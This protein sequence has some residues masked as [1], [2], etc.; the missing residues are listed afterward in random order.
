MNTRR[1]LAGFSLVELMVVVAVLAVVMALGIPSFAEWIANS[2]IRTAASSIL[3]GLQL[4]R[5]E[6]IRTNARVQFQLTGL[7]GGWQIAREAVDGT[8]QPQRCIFAG[9]ASV[10]SHPAPPSNA[11]LVVS[12]FSDTA[13]NTATVANLFIF[14]PNGWQGCTDIQPQQFFALGLDTTAI[15]EGNRN[16]RIAVLRGGGV[17]LCDPHASDT[18]A[19]LN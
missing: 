19:C 13:A 9:G 15:S 7:T 6:A 10:Q 8:G 4:A 17:R 12:P 3:N 11:L 5:S 14:G 16:L 18:R 2:R 1:D